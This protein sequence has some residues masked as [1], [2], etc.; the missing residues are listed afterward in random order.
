MCVR[1]FFTRA[2]QAGGDIIAKPEVARVEAR[3]LS[4]QDQAWA[5]SAVGEGFGEWA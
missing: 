4:G 1:I 3:M 2:G 5:D